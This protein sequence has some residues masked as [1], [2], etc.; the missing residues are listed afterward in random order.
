MNVADALALPGC[1]LPVQQQSA[2]SITATSGT[3]SQ[4]CDAVPQAADDGEE[5]QLGQARLELLCL[6]M[7]VVGLDARDPNL[8][9]QTR[10]K[11]T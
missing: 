6:M 11:C 7:Y 8:Q 9:M 2:V 3:H 4:P 5:P 10:R 1:V